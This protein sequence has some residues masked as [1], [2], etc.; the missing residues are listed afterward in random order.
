MALR[1]EALLGL[2]SASRGRVEAELVAVFALL[3]ELLDVTADDDDDIW[4]SG[5]RGGK[6]RL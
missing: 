1:E 3:L 5:K 4:I 2:V 6:R